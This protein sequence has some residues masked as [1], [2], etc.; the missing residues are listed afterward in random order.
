[1]NPAPAVQH[2][3]EI[4]LLTHDNFIPWRISVEHFARAQDVLGYLTIPIPDELSPEDLATHQAKHNQAQLLV[5]TTLSPDILNS[6]TDTELTGPLHILYHKLHTRIN[7]PNPEHT[8]DNLRRK[9]QSITWTTGMTVSEYIAKHKAIRTLMLRANYPQI[10]SEHTTL[11]FILEGLEQH[12]DWTAFLQTIHTHNALNPQNTLSMDRVISMMIKCAELSQAS[13]LSTP[14]PNPSSSFPRFNRR[15]RK[16]KFH[17]RASRFN[18]NNY[19]PPPQAYKGQWCTVH[20]TPTHNTADCRLRQFYMRHKPSNNTRSQT[21]AH[22][23]ISLTEDEDITSNVNPL[24]NHSDDLESVSYPHETHYYLD[25]GANPSHLALPPPGMTPNNS[26]TH[27]A[28]GSSLPITHRDELS[29]P[30]SD[31]LTLPPHTAVVSPSIRSNLLSV[32]EI[33]KSHDV[34][35][36]EDQAYIKRKSEPPADD[37]ILVTIPKSTNQLYKLVTPSPPISTNSHSLTARAFPQKP[38]TTTKTTSKTSKNRN[39]STRH[40]VKKRSAPLHRIEVIKRKKATTSKTPSFPRRPHK[41]HIDLPSTI[42][43]YHEWHLKMNHVHPKKLHYMAKHRLVDNLPKT[44]LRPPPTKFTCSGCA[45]GK[46]SAAPFHRRTRTDSIG[47]HLHTD[48][49]GPLPNTSLQNNRFFLTFLDEGSR[50]LT[51]HCAPTK[52]LAAAALKSHITNTHHHSPHRITDLTSDNAGEYYSRDMLQFYN[53]EL[54]NTH[55]TVPHTPQE[56]SLAERINRSLLDT[57][58][59]NLLTSRLPLSLWDYAI[60]AATD[61][62]NHS[63]HSATGQLPA[64]LYHNCTPQVDTLLPFGIPGF[65]HNRTPHKKL[66]PRARLVHYIG[67]SSYTHYHF[68]DPHTNKT[69]ICRAK[70][71]TIYNP[72]TDPVNT[73]YAITNTIDSNPPFT[74]PKTIQ[75]ARSAPDSSL[76][77][78]AW[79]NELDSLERRDILE[80]I[81]RSKLPPNTKLLPVTTILKFQQDSNGR[82]TLR[83]ARCTIRGDRQ[84][85]GTHYDPKDITSPVANRDSIRTALSLAATHD[86]KVYHWDLESAFLHERLPPN[87]EIYLQQPS[88][89]DGSK[90]YPNH[91]AKLK[92]NMYGSKQACKIFTDGLASHLQNIGFTRLFSDSCSFIHRDPSDEQSFVLLVITVD[93]FLVVTNSDHLVQNVK[94]AIQHKY[95]LKDLGTVE[96]ILGWKVTHSKEGILISQPAYIDS[97]LERFRLT[98]SKTFNSPIASELISAGN[99]T[100]SPLDT[101]KFDYKA[102][103]GSLRYVT[104]CTRP[105]IAFIVGFLGRFSNAPTNHH[106]KAALRVLRYLKNTRHTGILYKRGYSSPLTA[107][108]DADHAACPTTRRSTTGSLILYNNSPIAWQSKRQDHVA[109]STHHAEYVAS[110][111]TSQLALT[112]SNFLSET[113]HPT[114]SPVTIYIDNAAAI[115]TTKATFPTPKSRHI[116]IKYHWLREQFTN[117]LIAP[118]HIPSNSNP[119]DILTKALKP[120]QFINKIGLLRLTSPT[121]CGD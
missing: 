62:H 90:K 49:C 67:R 96:H 103:I 87:I 80:Y 69:G 35:F 99:N 63:P 30:I 73:S 108:S 9:A 7:A 100:D 48:I 70:D 105:D 47:S 45:I 2:Q 53:A 116:D 104:D 76:W 83:K 77:E 84:I 119:A 10:E 64:A 109:P 58:R 6:F 85:A 12:P 65:V 111:H 22:A 39:A 74:F 60:Y 102:L 25:S 86:Y 114:V 81:P 79:N 66:D 75:Q 33:T 18:A 15:Q 91:V 38:K 51:V 110:F 101:T 120:A 94:S 31:S 17:H 55:P 23:K 36:Q 97:L 82:P 13:R 4:P 34:L 78:L 57:A 88:R 54:I 32:S 71:F 115:T 113:G 98:E 93:D 95:T 50:Y 121:P 37:E 59:T 27:I 5:V 52:S 107:Y 20:G 112:L 24:F 46:R 61:T 19:F 40:R 29:I 89:F 106:W 1:M 117:K 26:I 11:Q 92:G 3:L 43:D 14:V 68:F 28:D 118:T 72:A 42:R 44:L 41:M 21:P 16:A 8:P 56:N